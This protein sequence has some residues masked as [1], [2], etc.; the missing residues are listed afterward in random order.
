[1]DKLDHYAI[2]LRKSRADLEA[3]KLG[4]GE[5][6]AKHKRI[7]TELA[8]R[9]NLYVAKIYQ[10]VVSGAD[11]I[12]DRKEIQ[13]L[14]SDCYAGM[15]RGII[16]MESTRLSRGSQADA[17]KI[18]DCLKFGNQNRGILVVTPTRTYDVAHNIDDEEYL[19]FELFMSRREYRMIQKR[20]SRGKDQCIVE[21]EFMG[22]HRP[23]G[24]NIVRTKAGR[25]LEPNET[26]ATIVKMIF[27]W[28]AKEKMTPGAIARRLTAMGVPTYT[29]IPEW[30]GESVKA[31]L[32]NPVYT[33]KVRW[34]DRMRV[35][36]MVNGEIVT[37]RPRIHQAEKYMLYEGMHKRHA[38]VD[39]E[40]FEAAN[41][42]FTR[43]RTRSTFKL[44]NPLAGIL[45]CKKCQ[46]V[47]IHQPYK[48]RPK[49]TPRFLH[50]SSMKCKVKSATAEDVM[51]AVVH[52]LR[53]YIEDFETKVDNL[54]DVDENE[55][56]AQIDALQKELT[57]TK[58]RLAKLFEAWE[59]ETISN[60]EFV[61]RKAVNN[62]KIESIEAQMRELE[63]AI[64]EQEEYS[65]K[66][67]MFSDA[68]DALL[69]N[70]I[71]AEIKNEYL[72]Q[73]IE[74]IEYSRENG[75]EFILEITLKE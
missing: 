68:L 10:E 65:E 73:I 5:T 62:Q 67:M 59:D 29:G 39:E 1:M 22:S 26:E 71:D 25:T 64:P 55:I 13:Q 38:L 43:D 15:H 2:Y 33:G 75:A 69:D 11:A 9:K 31:F 66:V 49:V 56:Q 41:K 3:E 57:K 14:I 52:A 8:V 61:E 47:M 72:K 42:R 12:E 54:P 60:N 46:R 37:K 7:L 28:A 48:N 44:H 19:E 51:S 58:K 21:G 32:T 17:Q 40:T 4:E 34:N 74:K 20:M 35:K 50:P 27:Q 45:V 53:L 24:Y 16:V 30:S 70:E 36:T 23:Y 6:L 18:L 63:N